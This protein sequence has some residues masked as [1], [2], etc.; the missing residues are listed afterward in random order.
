[1]GQNG[2]PAVQ[3]EMTMEADSMLNA[4]YTFDK[5]IV[6]KSNQ[7]AHAASRSVAE[8]PA[9]GYNPLFLYGG[10]GLG[11]THL[12]HAIGHEA[13]RRNPGVRV[14]YVTSEKFTNDLINAIREG[15]N[16]TFRNMYRNCDILLVDDSSTVRK[17]VRE[18]LEQLGFKNIDEASDGEAALARV[19]QKEYAL[20]IAD[21]HMAPM[22]GQILL[23]R[24]RGDETHK[25]LRFIMMTAEPAI[26][27]FQRHLTFQFLVGRQI[28]FAHTSSAQEFRDVEVTNRT[29]HQGS[30]LTNV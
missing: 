10:A 28:N 2:R 22:N 24:I 5:F 7:L 6:G 23:E 26:E 15:R 1:M 20:V 21:W 14:L 30:G 18:L 4:R 27:K 9:M 17:V 13:M 12:L 29:T 8:K 16:E 3:L 19:G 25:N 11:K